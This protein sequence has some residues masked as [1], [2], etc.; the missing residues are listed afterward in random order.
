MLFARAPAAPVRYIFS[1]FRT[2]VYTMSRVGFLIA[3][4]ARNGCEKRDVVMK[5]DKK[6]RVWLRICIWLITKGI[7]AVSKL[8]AR[9]IVLLLKL[10]IIIW[11]SSF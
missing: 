2:D 9:C 3:E 5:N 7:Y 1:F 6:H 11:L 8:R 4:T 10:F